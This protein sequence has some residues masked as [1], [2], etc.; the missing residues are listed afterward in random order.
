MYIVGI[1]VEN[2]K[3]SIPEVQNILTQYGNKITTRLG[4]HDE[5]IENRGIIITTYQAEDVQIFIEKLRA[6]ESVRVNYMEL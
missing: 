1:S 4:I 2:R 3:E 5:P 6:V